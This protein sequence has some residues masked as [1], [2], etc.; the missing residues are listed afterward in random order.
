MLEL[1]QGFIREHFAKIDKS[2]G[3]LVANYPKNG[4]EGYVGGNTLMEMTYAFSQGLDIYTMYD[5]PDDLN[6]TPELN[7]LSPIVLNGD[8]ASL[9]GHVESFPLAYVSSNSPV[10][11]I[12][13]GRG[14]RKA[15][16]SVRTK[17]LKVNSNV[18]EQ[19]M[20]IEETYDG[21]INRHTALKHQLGE[22]TADYY[23]TIESELTHLHEK[24]NVFGC[25]AIIIE[26]VGQ[27]PK[28]GID[29]DVEFPKSFTD[30][31][32]SVY[33]DIGVHVQKDFGSTLKDPYPFMTNE[34]LTRAKITE[35]GLYRVAVQTL[36]DTK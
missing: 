21:A 19:P 13:I 7:A 30:K 16:L 32:P 20:T 10:K 35:E 5:L 15:G 27:D 24:H 33:P 25:T 11:H 2:E 36:I 12:A 26:K 17:G 6:Y 31:V 22:T 23:V 1:K 14:F 28:V 9:H 29:V 8:V 34:K 4:V 3:I 18:N